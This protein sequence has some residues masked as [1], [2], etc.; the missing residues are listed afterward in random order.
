MFDA[1]K[2]ITLC[3]LISDTCRT[4]LLLV[5]RLIDRN[6]LDGIASPSWPFFIMILPDRS[7]NRPIAQIGCLCGRAPSVTKL[8]QKTHSRYVN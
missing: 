5:E 6:L 8:L 1:L 2:R 3:P 4:V 7:G